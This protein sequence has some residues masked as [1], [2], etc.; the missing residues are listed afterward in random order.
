MDAVEAWPSELKKIV[1]WRCYA[2]CVINNV[3]NVIESL[4][5]GRGVHDE[6]GVLNAFTI[7]RHYDAT[8]FFG[9]NRNMH[10]RIS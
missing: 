5:M 9:W 7:C 4:S 10:A 1:I 6:S 3:L 8:R 2:A